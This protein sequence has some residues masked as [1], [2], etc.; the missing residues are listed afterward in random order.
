M[1]GQPKYCVECK[2]YGDLYEQTLTRYGDKRIKMRTPIEAKE[3]DDCKGT[4]MITLKSDKTPSF[5]L[6][7]DDLVKPISDTDRPYPVSGA[8][9]KRTDDEDDA[10]NSDEDDNAIQAE[11]EKATDEDTDDSQPTPEVEKA[12]DDIVFE[13]KHIEPTEGEMPL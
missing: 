4:G 6:A 10:Q 9:K 8:W 1:P 13:P 11:K 12:D 3:C 2:G 7:N 5:D